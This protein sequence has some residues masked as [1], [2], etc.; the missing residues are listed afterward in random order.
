MAWQT[1]EACADPQIQLSHNRRI[2]QE[3]S[4]T[5]RTSHS[6]S[7]KEESLQFGPRE[8]SGQAQKEKIVVVVERNGE[9]YFGGLVTTLTLE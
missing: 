1:G 7:W 9:Q 5:T 4:T 2:S 3:N 8:A 6:Q